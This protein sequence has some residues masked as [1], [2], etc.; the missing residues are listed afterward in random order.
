MPNKNTKI[1]KQDEPTTIASWAKVVCAAIN[2]RGVDSSQLLERAEIFP[3]SL[4]DPEGRISVQKMSRLWALAVEAT[5][6]ETFGL[7]VPNFILPTSFHALGFSLMVSASLRDAWLRTQR[8]YKV[9]S[10]VL[11]IHIQQGSNESALCYVK[12]PGKEYATEAIDA[13]VATMVKLSTDITGGSAKPTKILL[14]R[15]EPKQSD[16][17]K[18][19][20]ACDIYFESGCNE[21]YYK[22]EDLDR[23]LTAANRDIALKNDE[24]VQSYLSRLLKQSLSRQVTEKIIMLLA[25][26]EPSQEVIANE[27]HLSSRQLQRKLKEESSSFRGLLEEVRKDLA[28]N[29]LARPQQSVIEIAFQLGFQDPSNFTRAFKRWFGVSPTSFRKQQIPL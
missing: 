8:Y 11:D 17:F 20:L 14:E 24:V 29:Y 9:V 28:K 4:I 5:G 18:V 22:N 10:D 1:V 27:L 3:D 13:F 6:D 7:S 25:M 26:G 2:A 15:K 16:C 21:I 12:V 19:S 23:I